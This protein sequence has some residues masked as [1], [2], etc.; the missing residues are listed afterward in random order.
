VISFNN[1]DSFTTIYLQDPAS[2]MASRNKRKLHW[3]Y[4][5]IIVSYCVLKSTC[6]T[7]M[8]LL[9][10]LVFSPNS[11]VSLF[12]IQKICLICTI[13]FSNGNLVFQEKNS[14]SAAPRFIVQK[15]KDRFTCQLWYVGRLG[16]QIWGCNFVI[17]K[18]FA[19]NLK[20]SI[21]SVCW[22]WAIFTIK[23]STEFE[24][25]ESKV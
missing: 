10:C 22:A 16:T 1:H 24:P 9:T 23:K 3:G 2:A 11:I 7:L 4:V 5:F 12:I 6:R 19:A 8:L 20:L 15:R 14:N 18:V 13:P 21:N 17:H 25:W